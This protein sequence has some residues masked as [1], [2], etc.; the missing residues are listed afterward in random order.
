MHPR[1]MLFLALP[2]LGG[3]AAAQTP[4]LPRSGET[5]DVSIVNVDVVVTD[6]SGRRVRGLTAD[7]FEVFE[8]G[9]LQP[10]S[11]F[12][13]Y[14][15][16]AD[17]TAVSVQGP[18]RPAAAPRQ[19]R[20]IVIFID[21]FHLPDFRSKPLFDGLRRSL[22]AIVRPGDAVSI[23]SWVRMPITR[24]GFTDNLDAITTTL[25]QIEKEVTWLMASDPRAQL[26]ADRQFLD[27][28]ERFAA[29]RGYNVNLDDQVSMVGLEGATRARIEIRRKMRAVRSLITLISGIEGKRAVILLSH[30]FSRV[31]GR[32]FTIN[33]DTPIGPS[34]DSRFDMQD[35]IRALI[36]TANANNVVLYPVYPV[37]I[38]NL[39]LPRADLALRQTPNGAV[40]YAVLNN[41][42]ESLTVMADETGGASEWGAE[43]IAEMLPTIQDD[44]ESYYSLAYRATPTGKD[45]SRKIEVRTRNRDLRVRSRTE[46]VEKSDTTKMKDRVIANLVA[47][48]G[49]DVI[50]ISVDVGEVRG[51]SRKRFR[52]PVTIRI[53]ISS[54]LTVERGA[55]HAG[56]FSVYVAWGGVLGE[57]SEATFETRTFEI[58]VRDLDRARASH[59]TYSLQLDSDALTE[60]VS[61]GVLD[62]VSK[63]FGLA[64]ITLPKRSRS[65]KGVGE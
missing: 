15:P 43:K 30:R 52:V 35:E 26:E 48:P 31:A 54:L 3:A 41:E 55:K 14:A 46:Y 29:S 12:A 16:A 49:G 19:R 11:N 47:S 53:P 60:R 13:E 62:E 21:R 45:K 22:R 25:N 24:L 10:I 63:D 40:D 27:E 6:K 56:A 50:P 58:P 28:I 4:S 20:T 33:P 42:L 8:N 18:A 36:Q 44:F 5:I 37:G 65:E 32:E 64:R 39:T 2:F 61:V 9:R 34:F 51:D 57:T 1:V 17:E 38:T 7:D 59:Y 23:V